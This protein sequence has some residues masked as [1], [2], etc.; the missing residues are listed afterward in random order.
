MFC[1]LARVE[2]DFKTCFERLRGL[3]ISPTIKKPQ[4]FSLIQTF[5]NHKT[6]LPVRGAGFQNLFQILKD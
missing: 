4:T 1:S 3:I 2:Q 5:G 6:L